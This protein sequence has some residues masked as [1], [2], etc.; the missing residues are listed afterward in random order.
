MTILISKSNQNI[1]YKDCN[2]LAKVS[3]WLQIMKPRVMS[4]AIFSSG[5]AYLLAYLGSN[6]IS[7]TPY[8]AV[9]SLFAIAIGS[10]G[11][12]VLNMW[13][14]IK[15]DALMK[16][17]LSRPGPRGVILP[18][19]MLAF[20]ISLCMLGIS[21]LLLSSNIIAAFLL[22]F[23]IFYYVVIYTII[24]KPRT[25]HS[26]SIGGIAGALPPV[27]GWAAT[28][29]SLLT[30]EPFLIALIIALWTPPHFW[31]L[32]II[33]KDEYKLANYPVHPNIIGVKNTTKSILLYSYLLFGSLYLPFL[34]E[35]QELAY[36]I[37]VTPFALYF[38]FRVHQL[39]QNP[40]NHKH[41]KRC[42]LTSISFLFSIL[43]I[44][45][46]SKLWYIF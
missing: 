33:Y 42:F 29:A 4:L 18:D 23:T 13:F 15:S 1:K 41:A 28:G 22:L 31:S 30:F 34:F 20:G 16:R 11:A 5:V 8:T 2:K 17:T 10:A 24:L 25:T 19:D 46:L 40:N 37:I 6:S 44:M 32:A 35:Y 38:L 26:I 9:L 12:G 14:E 43:L 27:I 39:V 21:I 36:A 7:L 3:D 45:L